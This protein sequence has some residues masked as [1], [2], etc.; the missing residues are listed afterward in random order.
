M[1]RQATTSILQIALSLFEKKQRDFKQASACFDV[2]PSRA[3]I[4]FRA[5]STGSREEE[6]NGRAKSRACRKGA[7]AEM[8]S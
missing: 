5:V 7:K 4:E 8:Y 6:N 3:G 2:F 1:T